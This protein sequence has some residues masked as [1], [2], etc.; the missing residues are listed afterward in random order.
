MPEAP[1]SYTQASK[2]AE[3]QSAMDDEF[4]TLMKNSTWSLVPARPDMNVVGSTWV[5]KT[6]KKLDGSL[7]RR[8]AQLVAKGYHQQQ[9]IDFDDTFS[10]VVKPPTIRLVLSIAVSH[11]WEIH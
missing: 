7:D 10:S 3:W 2:Y 9:G 8:K 4:S 6:K 11:N 1:S 5:L